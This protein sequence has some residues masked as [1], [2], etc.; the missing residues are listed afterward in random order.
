[1]FDAGILKFFI[2]TYGLAPYIWI[3]SLWLRSVCAFLYGGQVGD[4]RFICRQKCMQHLM[5][6]SR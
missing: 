3:I 4:Y 2:D 6:Q 1:M 5:L